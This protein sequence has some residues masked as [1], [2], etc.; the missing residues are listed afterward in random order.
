[1][2]RTLLLFI[3]LLIVIGI[4]LVALGFV[5]LRQDSNGVSIQTSDVEVGTTTTNV[6]LP[7]VRMEDRQ[8]EVPH[9]GVEN[10]A[11]AA[12]GQ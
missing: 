6:Q 9:V 2:L 12:N 5:N 1:M 4:G 7:V 3:V 8:V 11:A 10:E